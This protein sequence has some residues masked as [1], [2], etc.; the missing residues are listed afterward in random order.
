MKYQ[1][2]KKDNIVIFSLHNTTLDSL[3]AAKFKAEILNIAKDDIDG[4]VIDLSNVAYIDSSGIGAML[5]THRQSKENNFPVII[6]GIQNTV[7]KMF[8]ISHMD[9]FFRYEDSVDAAIDKLS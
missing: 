8:R 4:I 5:F 7:F 1:V 6:V 3:I 2:D 9:N